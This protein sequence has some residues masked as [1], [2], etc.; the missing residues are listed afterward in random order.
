MSD[1]QNALLSL[2]SQLKNN[3]LS[4]ITVKLKANSTSYKVRQYSEISKLKTS[5]TIKTKMKHRWKDKTK[6]TP[7]LSTDK[8]KLNITYYKYQEKNTMQISV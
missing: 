5:I 1:S 4:L 2:T 7:H 3:L 8:N 6:T